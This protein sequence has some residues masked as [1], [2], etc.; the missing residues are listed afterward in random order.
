MSA[1]RFYA[2]IHF[3]RGITQE[4]GPFRTYE[5]AQAAGESER[6]RHRHKPLYYTIE[7]RFVYPQN[8]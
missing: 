3:L 2:I 4:A 6:E 1:A 7:K 5:E 8:S